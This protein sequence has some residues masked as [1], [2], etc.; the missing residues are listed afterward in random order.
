[1]KFSDAYLDSFCKKN[2]LMASGVVSQPTG[3]VGLLLQQQPGT[4]E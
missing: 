4:A 3:A 1:M 2:P